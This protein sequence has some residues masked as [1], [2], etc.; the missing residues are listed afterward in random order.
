MIKCQV[1]GKEYDDYDYLYAYQFGTDDKTYVQCC[2]DCQTKMENKHRY[3]FRNYLPTFVNGELL[4]RIFD[5]KEELVNYLDN[6]ELI[7]DYELCIS[8]DTIIQIN[9]ARDTWFCKGFINEKIHLDKYPKFD[10]IRKKEE[11]KE[12]KESLKNFEARMGITHSEVSLEEIK[13]YSDMYHV[14]D[15]V[16]LIKDI[17]G[18]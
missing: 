18:V 7:T 17:K 12:S 2:S 9:K 16:K 5:T 3:W 11:V 1:C 14:D 4:T 13:D 8:G 15:M 10:D 6:L